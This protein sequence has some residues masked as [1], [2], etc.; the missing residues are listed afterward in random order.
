[1]NWRR[2]EEEERVMKVRQVS[3][4]KDLGEMRR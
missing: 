1:M 3:A 2:L 4:F